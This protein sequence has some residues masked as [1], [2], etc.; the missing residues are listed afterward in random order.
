MFLG[1]FLLALLGAGLFIG[2]HFTRKRLATLIIAKSKKAAELLESVSA[3][4]KEIGGGG[5]RELVE[6][7]G[8]VTCPSPLTSPLANQ[9]CVA[10]SMQVVREYEEDVEDRDDKGNVRRRTQRSSET[11]HSDSRRCDFGVRDTTGELPVLANDADFDGMV[12]TVSRF[13]NG[14]GNGSTI[15]LGSFNLTVNLGGGGRRRTLG[16]RYTESIFP[17]GRQ[18]T[19]IGEASDAD[20]RLTLRKPKDLSFIVSTRTRQELR[21]SAETTAK[22]LGVCGTLAFVA[23]VVVGILGIFKH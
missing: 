13:D 23:A 20:G 5:Y 14:A 12:E 4:G 17:I 15:S 16:Y 7:V 9:A 10:Y 19:I 11:I 22:I 21:G 1:A 18:V 6:I 8:D 3:V 2:V